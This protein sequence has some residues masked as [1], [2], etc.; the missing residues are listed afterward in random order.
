MSQFYL[1]HLWTVS[2]QLNTSDI[3]W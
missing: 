1:L 2:R 3:I